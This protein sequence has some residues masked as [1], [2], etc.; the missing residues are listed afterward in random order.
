MIVVASM[1]TSD[2]LGLPGPPGAFLA[3]DA[4]DPRLDAPTLLLPGN[5]VPP[6]A[7]EGDTLDV[8]VYLDSKD[9]PVATRRDPKVALGEVAFLTV[10]DVAPSTT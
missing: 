1:R 3:V 5:E 7:R 9:R 10:T 4:A 6:E 2:P 8:F